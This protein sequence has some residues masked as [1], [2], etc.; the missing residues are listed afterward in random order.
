MYMIA[1]IKTHIPNVEKASRSHPA[2]P[3]V[4]IAVGHTNITAFSRVPLDIMDISS[5]FIIGRASCRRQGNISPKAA[6]TAIRLSILL[7]VIVVVLKK[8]DNIIWALDI[9]LR[10]IYPTG[11]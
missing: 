11:I 10:D 7:P 1:F 8:P 5:L 6:N 4:I 2:I 9:C 3:S